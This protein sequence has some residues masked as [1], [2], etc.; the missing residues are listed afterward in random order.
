LR[1]IAARRRRNPSGPNKVWHGLGAAALSQNPQ[2]AL[3]LGQVAIMANL[4][5]CQ[6]DAAVT[7]A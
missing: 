2:F 3:V 5:H 6:L 1:H 4:R 7:E